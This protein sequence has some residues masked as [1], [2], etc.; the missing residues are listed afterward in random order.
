MKADIMKMPNRDIARW[1]LD[2]GLGRTR[3]MA[4]VAA[5][6]K[7]IRGWRRS[8]CQNFLGMVSWDALGVLDIVGVD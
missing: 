3:V 5:L 6:E 7:D 2:I 4:D 8:W 1:Y